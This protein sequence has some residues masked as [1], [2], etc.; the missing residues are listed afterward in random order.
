MRGREKLCFCRNNRLIGAPGKF[1]GAGDVLYRQRPYHHIRLSLVSN[2]MYSQH[3]STNRV[4]AYLT[5]YFLAKILATDFPAP[6][7][8]PDSPPLPYH[9]HEI[10]KLTDIEKIQLRKFLNGLKS[11]KYKG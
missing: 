9:S 8:L 11:N 1:Y 3:Q 4:R 2:P 5:F 6:T 10:N 7:L